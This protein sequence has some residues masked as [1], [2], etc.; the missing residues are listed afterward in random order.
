MGVGGSG[1]RL[2]RQR[3]SRVVSSLPFQSISFQTFCAKTLPAAIYNNVY[4][5]IRENAVII[6]NDIQ[7]T[8]GVFLSGRA[9]LLIII[10]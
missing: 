9:L 8:I 4:I 2:E 6:S 7:N 5:L 3:M 1:V 10:M